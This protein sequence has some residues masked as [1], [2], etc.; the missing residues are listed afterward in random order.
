MQRLTRDQIFVSYSHEDRE[1]VSQLR[2]TLKA[3]AVDDTVVCWSDERIDPG[4][5][6]REEL[7]A[8]L[9]RCKVAVLLVTMEFL[10]SDFIRNQELPFLMERAESHKIK[11]LWIPVRESPYANFKFSEYQAVID[12]AKPMSLMRSQQRDLAWKKIGEAI[13]KELNSGTPQSEVTSSSANSRIESH[14]PR[15]LIFALEQA[16]VAGALQSSAVALLVIEALRKAS[17]LRLIPGY[18]LE[19]LIAGVRLSDEYL[20]KVTKSAGDPGW[21]ESFRE[22]AVPVLTSVAK[23]FERSASVQALLSRLCESIAGYLELPV[24]WPT[25]PQAANDAKSAIYAECLASIEMESDAVLIALR[26]LNVGP[27]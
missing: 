25:E 6:W 9:E 26:A 13:L 15:K 20:A 24:Y 18:D 3:F 2:K 19:S 12:P 16:Y 23:V 21:E 5:K 7:T 27:K 4:A 8:A 1:W 22:A 11:L 10:A 14:G 17:A